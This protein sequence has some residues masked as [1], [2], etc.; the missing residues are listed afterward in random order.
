M[1]KL[2]VL[3]GMP[4]AGKDTQALLLEKALDL[5]VIR[6]GDE[7]RKKA[8]NDK[9]LAKN[10]NSGELANE[11]MVDK[12]V[13]DIL[14]GSAANAHLLSDGYPRSYGQ[15]QALQAMTKKL[16]IEIEKVLYLEITEAEVFA[17]LK[18]R[19]RADDDEAVIANR[20]EVFE[21]STKPVLEHFESLGIL[22][23]IDG[24][25]TIEQV[26]SRIQEALKQ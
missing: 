9:E 21:E 15:A 19:A 22:K 7:V 11:S 18:L 3:M 20:L 16:D 17:R 4:G 2:I 8:K 26:Q 1:K 24:I 25:G 13:E 5:K 10:I 23:R 6:V 12:I 14:K